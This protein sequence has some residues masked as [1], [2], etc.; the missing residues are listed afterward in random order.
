[1]AGP[2]DDGVDIS[3]M[4]APPA[5]GP[6]TADAAPSDNVDISSMPDP[7][8]VFKQ[9]VGRDPEGGELAN[10]KQFPEN[11]GSG[12]NAAG[13]LAAQPDRKLGAADFP[14]GLGETAANQVSGILSPL[15]GGLTYLG[16]LAST[17]DPDAAKAVKDA[18]EDQ[19]TYSPKYTSTGAELTQA[20]G[21]VVAAALKATHTPEAAKAVDQH[22][23]TLFGDN[24]VDGVETSLRMAGSAALN[25]PGAALARSG[26]NALERGG[27]RALGA[28]ADAADAVRGGEAPPG[29]QYDQGG[30]AQAPALPNPNAGVTLDAHQDASGAWTTDDFQQL[31]HEAPTVPQEPTAATPPQ[32]Q[33]PEASGQPA[34]AA[35]ATPAG[36]TTPEVQAPEAI[37]AAPTGTSQDRFL[38]EL[39]AKSTPHP[40]DPTMRKVNDNVSVEAVKDPFDD[41]TVHIQ[42]FAADS[43]QKGQG[44][45]AMSDLTALADK[46][47]TTLTLDAI[48]Q[49]PIPQNRLDA[50]YKAHGFESEE[51]GMSTAGA[52]RRPPMG[53]DVNAG[54]L[55]GMP[56]VV[57]MNGKPM[58]FG[59]TPAART[60]A[61]NYARNA[62]LS[63]SPPNTFEPITPSRGSMIADAYDKMPHNPDDPETKASYNAL[64]KETLAQWDSIKRTG[65][66]VDFKQP[67][68]YGNNPRLAVLDVK[69][70]NHL[71]V[72]PTEAGEGGASDAPKDHP[73][74]RP[75][76]VTVD[77]RKLNA[78]DV[79]RIVH[80]YYGHVKEGNGFRADGEFN[81][82][83]IHK[84]MYSPLAQK[85][86]A[87][88]TL[89]QNA[90][91]NYGPEAGKNKGA[92]GEKTV[93]A[94]QKAGLLPDEAIRATEVPATQWADRVHAQQAPASATA[95]G[96]SQT[97]PTPGPQARSR[98]TTPAE[99][100]ITTQAAAPHEQDQRVA[101]LKRALPELSEART[102]AVSNDYAE[103]G[104][105]YQSSKLKDAVGARARE[106]INNEQ[107]A[108]RN[109]TSRMGS[110]TDSSSTAEAARGTT[111]ATAIDSAVDHFKRHDAAMYDRAKTDAAQQPAN[112]EGFQALTNP[113]EGE[114]MPPDFLASQEGQNLYRGLMAQA[115]VLG[116][117]GRDGKMVPAS[118]DRIDTLRKFAV[119]NWAPRVSGLI[120][121][122]KDTLDDDLAKS[123]GTN[124]YRA[125]RQ[126]RTTRGNLFDR[127]DAVSPYMAADDGREANRPIQTEKIMGKLASPATS[128]TQ[129]K[130]VFD[131]LR[132]A[133][134][135]FEGIGDQA[136]ADDIKQKTAAALNAARDHFAAGALKAGQK[137]E[138]GWDQK[139][140]SNYL[141]ENEGK[142]AT[143][144]KPGDMQRWQ[145]I[146]DAGNILRMDRSYP[147]AHAQQVNANALR[148]KAAEVVEGV[149]TGLGAHAG[150]PAGAVAGHVLGPRFGALVRGNPE[151][152]AVAQYNKRI[153]DLG[154]YKPQAGPG[155]QIPI[156]RSPGKFE[157]VQPDKLGSKL[158]GQRGGPKFAGASSA[159]QVRENYLTPQESARIKT[160]AMNKLMD[161]FHSLPP[162]HEYAAAA[163]AGKAKRGWYRKSAEAISNVFGPDAPRFTAVLAAMSPQT[164]VQA[165]FHNALRTFI[166]WDKAGRP[167][168]ATAIHKI[169]QDSVMRRE[170]GAGVLPAWMPNT[171]RALQS[172]DPSHEN[173]ALSGPKVDS[174]MRNLRSDTEAVTNDAWMT[175]FAKVHPNVLKGNW[176][177][178]EGDPGKRPGYI[179][180]SAKVREAARMLSHMTGERWTP[181]E[182]QETVWSWA[183]TAY[184]HA[185]QHGVSIPQLVK[186]GR[187][188]D[189]LIRSTPDFHNLFSTDEHAGFIRGSRYAANA[190]RMAQPTESGANT[191]GSSQKSAA[192]EKALRSHLLSAARRLESVRTERNTKP[193]EE[194][195]DN[196]RGTVSDEAPF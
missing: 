15:A 178:K 125:A 183:K 132:S 66:N 5:S 23:R 112:M 65:L 123:M 150:G 101:T 129:F 102:S 41:S 54:P 44:G 80:D 119:A 19:L 39:D 174:F 52:M 75:T 104:N 55:V 16:T 77:G 57:Q 72:F 97:A 8:T 94:P 92:N 122:I 133:A 179:A 50:F 110:N 128:T 35:A 78:N 48:P 121:R 40:T 135:Y 172:P 168:D 124:T 67:Y 32:G 81:A 53:P 30:T 180:M 107:Q 105:D 192:T 68:P 147:G 98:F 82:Y 18:T 137:V 33:P 22:M 99:E 190:E 131:S 149:A 169:A 130:A 184:E 7:A 139:S 63:Y 106:V 89:G 120:G 24:F 160:S 182:V 56:Q 71:T 47:G 91:V 164:S 37:P 62:G 140:F 34:Q 100:G 157:T 60:A 114:Q 13:M 26:L 146:N 151:A 116:L 155:A 42:N 177:V 156:P 193:A 21:A 159:E 84:A 161:T 38:Q 74:L 58:K 103:A 167:T 79:F 29:T 64:I 166:N 113:P 148:E 88:E 143:V 43:P 85:A 108:L 162:S 136:A 118:A 138:R 170:G 115:R 86:L 28:A 76:N 127:N 153:T 173:F 59:P 6:A 187:L 109:E 175:S 142:L 181:R 69:H 17:R 185:D 90:W 70:N 87:T 126:N 158:P 14:V 93:Y 11:W 31:D 145:D 154:A 9:Q 171:I 51:S 3:G 96:S 176:P 134:R 144:N 165:N 45:K 27:S 20:P 4:P 196:D 194:I 111:V 61:Y 189:E 191:T 117:V 83:R 188:T 1:M 152:K 195:S 186:N 163:L 2:D 10:F 12:K 49:G 46:H 36:P 73:M 25:L 141:K 95:G